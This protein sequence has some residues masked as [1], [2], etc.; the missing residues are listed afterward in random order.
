MVAGGQVLG[1]DGRGRA[2]TGPV[3][4]TE[5]EMSSQINRDWKSGVKYD[6]K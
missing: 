2:L 3:L 5:K 1:E 4:I 6:I